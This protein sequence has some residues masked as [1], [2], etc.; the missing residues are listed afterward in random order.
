MADD[1][2]SKPIPKTLPCLLRCS[3]SWTDSCGY[4]KGKQVSG[5][6]ISLLQ[7]KDQA[8]SVVCYSMQDLCNWC[9]NIPAALKMNKNEV[10]MEEITSEAKEVG[11]H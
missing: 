3:S 4:F 7:W 11:N 10:R 5:R 2:F 6:M 1:P 8:N 9:L